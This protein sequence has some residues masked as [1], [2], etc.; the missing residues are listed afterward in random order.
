MTVLVLKQSIDDDKLKTLLDLLKSWGVDVEVRNQ[1]YKKTED[2]SQQQTFPFS[3]G[4]WNGYKIDDK[5][6]RNSAWNRD[7]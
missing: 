7:V 1:E 6:L 2:L 4:L 3:I 5:S